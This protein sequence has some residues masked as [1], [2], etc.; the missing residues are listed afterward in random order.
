MAQMILKMTAVTALYV[1]LTVI[2]W[3]IQNNKKLS[4][5]GILGIGVFYGICSIL[6]THFAVDYTNMLLNVR[7][8][9]P[10]AAGLFFHPVSGLI[11]GLIGGIERYIAGTWWGIG[12]FTRIACSVS[13]CLAG[14]VSVFMSIYIFKR[15]KPAPLYAFFMGA[16]MEV[17][18]MYVVLITH[19]TNMEMAY[20]VVR[21]CSGPMIIFTGLGLAVSSALLQILSGEWRNPFKSVPQEHEHL[22]DHFQ[23]RLFIGIIIVF[24]VNF[25]FTY[26]IQSQTAVQNAHVVLNNKSDNIHKTYRKIMNSDKDMESVYYA[27]GSEGTFDIIKPNGII[28]EGNHKNF[29]LTRDLTEKILNNTDDSFFTATVFNKESLCRTDVLDDGNIL[30]TLM[31]LDEVYNDRDI[32]TLETVYADILLVA[33]V[34]VLI[35]FLVQQIVVNNLDLVNASLNKITHGNLNE[36]VNVKSSSEFASLSNDI[37]QTVDVLKG[38][39]SAA[40]KRYEEELE[41][42]RTIQDSALPKNFK[43]PRDDFEIYATMDPAKEVGGDFYDFFFTGMNKLALVIADVSG[44]GIPAS[45]F[46][47]RSK[48]AIKGLAEEGFSPAEVLDKANNTLCDG[49]DAEMFVTVWLGIIDLETGL[50]QCANAGHEYPTLKRADGTFELIKDK[51]SLAL[52]AMPGARAKEYE[53]RL[54]PG[55]RLFVYTDGVPEAINEQTEQYG[56]ERMLKVLDRDKDLPMEEILPDVRKDISDFTGNAEQFDDITMLGFTY[57]GSKTSDQEIQ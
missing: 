50:M 28:S 4:A 41:L 39:I 19:R 10:L 48:T 25:S 11:A 32:H 34:Y 21:I 9:G 23:T 44:K 2:I 56:D 40:E 7:D 1:L 17:F 24:A 8:I 43:F 31:P 36:V 20:Y 26:F 42:A 35:S 22:S 37:N 13:T 5:A 54:Q 53:I 45:L 38:Y 12:S 29:S 51:H 33:T 15:K 14:F 27:G 57:K 46:M 3:K 49:N 16:V 47:M 52:A 30:L 6:S 18:H 55:D